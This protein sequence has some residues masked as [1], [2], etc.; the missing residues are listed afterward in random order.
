MGPRPLEILYFFQCGDRLYTT[1]S[2]VIRRQ[3]L[4]YKDDPRAERAKGLKHR[5]TGIISTCCMTRRRNL[6]SERGGGW[7]LI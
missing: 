5:I 1:E 2:D 6:T 7:G 3:I 4:T